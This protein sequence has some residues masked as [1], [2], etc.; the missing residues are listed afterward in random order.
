[1]RRKGEWTCVDR[2]APDIVNIS[3]VKEEVPYVV[4]IQIFDGVPP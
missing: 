3:R 1:M 4:E 2:T